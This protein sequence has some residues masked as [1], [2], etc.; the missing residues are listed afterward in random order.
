[1]TKR[2]RIGAAKRIRVFDAASGICHM[3][4][5]PINPWKE[6]WDVEHFDPLWLGGEDN[7]ANM[8]P[9][10]KDCHAVKSAAEATLRA[11]G[12]RV[13]ARYLGVKKPGRTIP[14]RKFDGTPIPSRWR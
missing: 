10:H 11:K 5:H 13:R 14:G 9:A 12:T 4:K 8:R 1:M 3:C 6:R 2:K 7:E